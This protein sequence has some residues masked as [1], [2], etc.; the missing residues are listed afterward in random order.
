MGKRKSKKGKRRSR[1]GKKRT[2]KNKKK[3]KQQR[4][5]GGLRTTASNSTCD[6]KGLCQKI[7]DYIKYS[8]QLRKLKRI[9]KTCETMEKKALKAEAG[10]FNDTTN[11]NW[12][13]GN[14]TV[15][16]KTEEQLDCHKTAK[17][18]CETKA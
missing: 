1:K 13:S 6:V 16:N 17:E 2:R 7:K 8:N 18:H 5:M 9:N 3:S 4:K 11:A 15:D 10:E 14:Y 12:N